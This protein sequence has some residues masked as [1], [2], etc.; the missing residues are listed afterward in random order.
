MQ[1]TSAQAVP[2]ECFFRAFRYLYVAKRAAESMR[3]PSF[4]RPLTEGFQFRVLA[5][6][7]ILPRLLRAVPVFRRPRSSKE[8]PRSVI[9]FPSMRRLLVA[10]LF[11]LW[12]VMIAARS[13][14]TFDV[15]FI[16]VE[17]GQAT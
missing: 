14:G 9:R 7:P 16:D 6:E 1:E 12:P 3:Y 4:C 5:E 8:H 2:L 17:G 15:Y 13:S 11:L 10:S